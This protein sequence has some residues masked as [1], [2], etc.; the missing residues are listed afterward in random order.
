MSMYSPPG[1]PHGA[2]FSC[3]G[4]ASF[5][6]NH[7]VEIALSLHAHLWPLTLGDKHQH[8]LRYP[9]LC[10]RGHTRAALQ[11]C[12]SINIESRKRCSGLGLPI[13]QFNLHPSAH[14]EGRASCLWKCMLPFQH[15]WETKTRSTKTLF[16][17]PL[18]HRWDEV[19][20]SHQSHQWKDNRGHVSSPGL[21]FFEAGW[22]PAF[23]SSFCQ[24]DVQS[25]CALGD[26]QY[27][28]CK[29]EESHLLTFC[30][31][32]FHVCKEKSTI[33]SWLFCILSQ[34]PELP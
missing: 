20:S 13:L 6:W 14:L 8:L 21:V 22:L 26:G 1:L 30:T 11:L 15:F 16:P 28:A 9:H 3:S 12:S 24:L 18:E 7:Q 34:H 23:S 33:L 31:Q 25:W 32:R 19:T 5:W 10:P 4:E 2:W 17:A 27:T 29:E